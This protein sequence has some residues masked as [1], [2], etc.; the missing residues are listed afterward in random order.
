M[1]LGGLGLFG[2]AVGRGRGSVGAVGTRGEGEGVCDDGE[3][4]W[5]LNVEWGLGRHL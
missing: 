1:L 2:K 3:V 4:L 5:D